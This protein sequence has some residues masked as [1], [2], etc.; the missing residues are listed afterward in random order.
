MLDKLKKLLNFK[1]KKEAKAY[2][3]NAGTLSPKEIA[4][5]NKEPFVSVLT[6]HVNPDN[7]RNGFFELDWNEYFI[8]QLKSHGYDGPTEESIIDAWF[9]SLCRNIGNEQGLDM[10][11][12][13]SGYINVQRIGDNR[14]EVS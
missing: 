9:Q 12:R 11:K 2:S 10:D 1:A 3:A 7:I 4:T 8:V 6:T 14:S 5:A 13:G